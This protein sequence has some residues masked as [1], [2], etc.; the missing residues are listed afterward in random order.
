M[1][2]QQRVLFCRGKS[3]DDDD[4]QGDRYEEEFSRAGYD[5][6]FLQILEHE[7]SNL[8][9]LTQILLGKEQAYGGILITSRRA[10]DTL[11]IAWRNASER[12]HEFTTNAG[13][14]WREKLFFVVGKGTAMAAR[15]A[16]FSPLGEHTGNAEVLGPFITAQWQK[17]RDRR[18]ILFL[19]GDKARDVLPRF[20]KANEVPY[21]QLEAYHTRPAQHLA[22]TVDALE[23]TISQ[24]MLMHGTELWVIFFSPSGVDMVYPVLQTREWWST[25]RC[26]SIGPTTTRH[27]RELGIEVVAEASAPC[28]EDLLKAVMLAPPSALKPSHSRIASS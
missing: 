28:P 12:C 9:E 19:A 22:K 15:E 2:R 13:S 14:A 8:N 18:P 20:L 24:S 21:V 25:A 11:M 5:C 1:S 16:G 6:V 23:K 27:M 10:V 3:V 7:V 26:A 17:R 4:S